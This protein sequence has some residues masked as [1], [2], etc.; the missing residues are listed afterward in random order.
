MLEESC[1]NQHSLCALWAVRG[2]CES[3]SLAMAE[4][5]QSLGIRKIYLVFDVKRCP[6][7][8]DTNAERE[9]R[10]Q[11]NLKEARRLKALGQNTK[12]QDKY[13]MCVKGTDTMARI[14]T[15]S[16]QKARV[17]TVEC[18]FSPFEADAQ[19][20]KLVVDGHAHAVVTEDSDILV[21]SARCRVAFPIIL[22]LD[23]SRGSCQIIN[24]DWLLSSS[25]LQPSQISNDTKKKNTQ[26]KASTFLTTIRSF[27]FAERQCAGQGVRLF[28]QACV[29]SG[30]DYVANSISGVGLVHAFSLVN[31]HSH[32]AADKSFHTILQ[33][34]A[35]PDL[36]NY[37]KL[38]SKSEVV[39]YH[40]IL[41]DLNNM[42]GNLVPLIIPGSM[43]ILPG[44]KRFGSILDF[45][46]TN[47]L[48][49][50]APFAECDETE[51]FSISLSSSSS[52]SITCIE[53]S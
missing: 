17:K 39:F 7:K 25:I 2:Y 4:K 10:R 1:R 26:K 32:V 51:D 44:L 12:A 31:Q 42:S 19:L 3:H 24:M 22:K 53:S 20:V 28:V 15:S 6:L 27:A 18:V 29:L 41:K 21:Y 9:Q 49:S 5:L 45:V 34:K 16:F 14:V 52:Q 23:R 38:L 43:S 35:V 37:E 11:S 40:H 46:G 50:Y 33:S 36:D 47:A 8:A 48:L 13:K 30:C